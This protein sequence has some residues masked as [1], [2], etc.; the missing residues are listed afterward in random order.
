[1]AKLIECSRVLQGNKV[2]ICKTDVSAYKIISNIYENFG[3]VI[4]L[5]QEDDMDGNIHFF[6]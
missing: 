3:I 4:A 1:M 2:S 5:L 6:E